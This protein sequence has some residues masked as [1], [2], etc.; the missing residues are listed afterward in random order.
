MIVV[1]TKYFVKTS[2]EYKPWYFFERTEYREK[3][4]TASPIIKFPNKLPFHI[5][6]TPNFGARMISNDPKRPTLIPSHL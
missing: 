6:A 5:E 1:T 4:I 2:G 3:E